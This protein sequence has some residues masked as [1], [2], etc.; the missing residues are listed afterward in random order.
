[1]PTTSAMR[2]SCCGVWADARHDGG[3]ETATR[4][5]ERQHDRSIFERIDG[6]TRATPRA[7][8]IQMRAEVNHGLNKLNRT[9]GNL[10]AAIARRRQEESKSRQ[11]ARRSQPHVPEDDASDTH[12]CDTHAQEPRRPPRCSLKRSN[13]ALHDLDDCGM[14]WNRSDYAADGA[15][16]YAIIS[17]AAVPQSVDR[18]RPPSACAARPRHCRIGVAEFELAD[19]IDHVLPDGLAEHIAGL[20]RS[21]RLHRGRN[22]APRSDGICPGSACRP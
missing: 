7:R 1:M 22:A 2:F 18:R 16:R 11:L 13:K 4:Q 15:R 14:L 10:I 17:T 21:H 9:R 8:T 20:L 6:P 5:T 12:R 19:I 3:H